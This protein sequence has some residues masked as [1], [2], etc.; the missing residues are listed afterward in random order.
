MSN[1]EDYI[2]VSCPH[3]NDKILIYIKELNCRIFR[4]GIYKNNYEQIPPHLE[5]DKCIQLKND[6][7]IIGCGKPFMINEDNF[8]IECEYI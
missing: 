2:V 8:A 7:L 6:D 3:C 4:H 5:K 1:N